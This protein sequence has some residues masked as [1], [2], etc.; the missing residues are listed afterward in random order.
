MSGGITKAA[1]SPW[2][3]LAA[4]LGIQ[5]AAVAAGL[6]PFAHGALFDPDCYARLLKAWQLL[7]T[8][9]WWDGSIAA[10]DAPYGLS[11]HWTRPLDLLLLALALPLG[12]VMPLRDALFGAGIVISPLLGLAAFAALHRGLAPILGGGAFLLAA[13]LLAAQRGIFQGFAIGR[14]D[15]HSLL[16]ALLAAAFAVLAR[17]CAA[18]SG[19]TAARRRLAVLAALGALA[20]WVNPEGLLQVAFALLCL[21]LRAVWL[22]KAGLDDLRDYALGLTAF[23]ALALAAERPPVQWAVAEMDRLSLLHVGL[24]AAAALVAVPAAWVAAGCRTRRLALLATLAAAAAVLLAWVFPALLQGAFAGVGP[25]GRSIVIDRVSELQPLWPNTPVRLFNALLDLGGL[26]AAIAFTAAMALGKPGPRRSLALV[27]ACGLAVFVPA[28][29]HV[30]REA[31]SAQLFFAVPLAEACLAFGAATLAAWR[32]GHP[33]AALAAGL[34]G[35]VL[36]AGCWS[37]AA[38]IHLTRWH[39]IHLVATA[40]CDYRRLK[41][42]GGAVLATFPLEE[43]PA[44]AWAT[45][46]PAVSGPYHRNEEGIRDTLAL[47]GAQSDAEALAVVRR[48]GIGYLTVCRPPRQ[49][50]VAADRLLTRLGRG[51]PPAWLTPVPGPAAADAPLLFRVSP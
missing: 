10:L 37:T 16:L 27:N 50:V 3:P 40:P 47:F 7:Q 14:P 33:P 22:G 46:R 28:A 48:R 45:G 36:V 29:L 6:L 41:I 32:R 12:A 42:D 15:H 11:M 30:V 35:L 49:G 13:I 17:H 23:A 9:A 44:A 18:E 25:L 26:P 21:G 2:P 20:V 34:G 4:F 24:A 5:A 1:N 31:A 38:A 51:A 43:G 19:G 39:G 8:G